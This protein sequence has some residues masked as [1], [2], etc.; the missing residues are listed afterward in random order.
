METR[1]IKISLETA[2]RWHNGT[3]QELKNELSTLKK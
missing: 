1:E 3:D 2:T